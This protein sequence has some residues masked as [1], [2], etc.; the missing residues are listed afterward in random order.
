MELF[1][2]VM[3][4]VSDPVIWTIG[5]VSAVLFRRNWIESLLIAMTVASLYAL[6]SAS[7][8]E[9]YV[10]SGISPLMWALS[11]A[12]VAASVW[13]GGR[14]VALGVGLIAVTRNKRS[15]Q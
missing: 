8:V 5:I 11:G 13:C 2:V 4:S 1:L 10:A 6:A 14:I 9:R 7:I 12:I 15:H 3:V